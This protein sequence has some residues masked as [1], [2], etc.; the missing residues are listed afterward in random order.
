MF[1]D[2]KVLW[3]SSEGIRELLIR[4]YTEKKSIPTEPTNN[5]RLLN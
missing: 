1:K 4:Y 3:R 5:W 2:A